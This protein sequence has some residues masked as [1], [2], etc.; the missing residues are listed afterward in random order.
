MHA[1][2]GYEGPE[3][4]PVYDQL[5][6]DLDS[7]KTSAERLKDGDAALTWWAAEQTAYL[8]QPTVEQGR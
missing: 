2:I 1:S 8:V 4:Q 5:A 6:R 7:V 3:M